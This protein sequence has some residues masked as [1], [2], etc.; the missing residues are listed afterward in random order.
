MI[1]AVRRDILAMITRSFASVI[2]RGLQ[3]AL[4][5]PPAQSGKHKRQSSGKG[6]APEK[7]PRARKSESTKLVKAAKS[8]LGPLGSGMINKGTELNAL[9]A[10]FRGTS[11]HLQTYMLTA[12]LCPRCGGCAPSAATSNKLTCVNNTMKFLP[13]NYRVHKCHKGWWKV[14]H[15]VE[16]KSCSLQTLLECVSVL[17]VLAK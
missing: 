3:R 17:W 5:P 14:A 8:H 11:R 2:L 4:M 15:I 16:C 1:A 13:R 9:E 7:G 10:V 12:L 6:F